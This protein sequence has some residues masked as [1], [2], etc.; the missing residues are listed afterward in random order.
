MFQID[1]KGEEFTVQFYDYGNI[2]ACKHEDLRSTLYMTEV[3]QLCLKGFFSAIL[4]VRRRF[5]DAR[6]YVPKTI[7]ILI[8]IRLI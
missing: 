4:P 5:V 7:V 3:P 8:I 6:D 1:E 2:E